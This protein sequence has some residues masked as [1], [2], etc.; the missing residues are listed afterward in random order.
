LVVVACARSR[1]CGGSLTRAAFGQ[2]FIGVSK[3]GR[4]GVQLFDAQGTSVLVIAFLLTIF[5]IF[6]IF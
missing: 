5:G 3:L 4:E 6:W 1:L 2:I